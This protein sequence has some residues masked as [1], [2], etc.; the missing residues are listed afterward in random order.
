MVRKGS[1]EPEKQGRPRG[2][3]RLAAHADVLIGWVEEDGD[4]N[5]LRPFANQYAADLTRRREHSCET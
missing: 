2:S 3:G 4:T 5:R 1:L